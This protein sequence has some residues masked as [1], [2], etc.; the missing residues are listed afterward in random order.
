MACSRH[1]QFCVCGCTPVMG[2][3]HPG[4]GLQ[5]LL[6]RPGQSPQRP[7]RTRA[8]HPALTSPPSPSSSASLPRA[9]GAGGLQLFRQKGLS[10]VYSEDVPCRGDERQMDIWQNFPP[11]KFAIP[12]PCL[13]RRQ[14]TVAQSF[15][16]RV[17]L[18]TA[19]VSFWTTTLQFLGLIM[20]LF[21]AGLSKALLVAVQS[22]PGDSPSSPSVR[23][24]AVLAAQPSGRLTKV[25]LG[26]R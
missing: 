17:I 6:G 14:G 21:R 25:A 26:W 1:G 5:S 22:S 11:E 7:G 24:P 18:V 20:A 3:G 15:Q 4:R 13:S 10:P 8:A 19:P 23:H 2:G 16:T 12:S 9:L